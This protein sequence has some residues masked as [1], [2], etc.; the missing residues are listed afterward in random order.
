MT[1]VFLSSTSRDLTQC[2]EA[3]R[4]AINGLHGYRCR[5][6]EDFGSFDETPDEFCVREVSEC[7]LF[8]CIAGH[9][10]G[11]RSPTGSS[12]CEREFETA[13]NHKKS[14]L[15]FLADDDFPLAANLRESDEDRK[16]QLAFRE[17]VSKDRGITRFSRPEQISSLVV[18]AIR[19]WEARRPTQAS[20][21]ASQ[22]KRVSYSVAVLNRSRQLSD[23]EVQTAVAALQKQVHDDF[24]PVWGI[25]ADL[26]FVAQGSLPKPKSWWLLIE[27]E[28]DHPE[29]IS[30]H[31]LN[32]EGLPLVKISVINAKRADRDWTVSASHELL[33]TLANPQLNLTVFVARD[34]GSGMLYLREICD[35]V[36]ST[37]LTYT[38]D[39]TIVSNFVY[40]AWFES[41]HEPGS[42]RFDHCGHISAPFQRTLGGY[43]SVFEVREGSGWRREWEDR[44]QKRG[45]KASRGVK[46]QQ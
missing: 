16:C 24:A 10:Y 46:Q 42:T 14:I 26:T 35:P 13:I 37:K 23:S 22:I 18:Q 40:P 31:T 39:G 5:R 12:Y 7:D 45:K 17:R 1:T 43:T 32:S 30:Y 25:D 36:T 6:M 29:F 20:L 3:A 33:E 21:V 44:Q 27:D 4:D 41:L 15:A 2:R 28:G 8:V 9:L 38:I 19:N 34:R 11:S